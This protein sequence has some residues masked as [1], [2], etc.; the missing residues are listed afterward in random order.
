MTIC[1]NRNFART[2]LESSMMYSEIGGVEYSEAKMHNCCVDGIYFESDFAVEPG[3]DIHIKIR[4]N[5]PDVDYSPEAYRVYQA[6]VRWC[7]EIED[8]S[9]Y[10][11]GVQFFKPLNQKPV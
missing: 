5:S 6:K 11:I 9:R 1:T 8:S 3:Y 7:K 2:Y 4:N 10:G